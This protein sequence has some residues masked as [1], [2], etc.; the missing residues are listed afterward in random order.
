MNRPCSESPP[1]DTHCARTFVS[2][3][4]CLTLLLGI[5]LPLVYV[6]T[7]AVAWCRSPSLVWLH[8]GRGVDG[9]YDQE[10]HLGWP[11]TYFF[12]SRSA[13]AFARRPSS[14]WWQ[15]PFPAR[16]VVVYIAPLQLVV[17][18]AWAI[19]IVYSSRRVALR[20]LNADG[21][22]RFSLRTAFAVMTVSALLVYLEFRCRD[23]G[24]LWDG[25]RANE[26]Y[27]GWSALCHW[28]G[29]RSLYGWLCRFPVMVRVPIV[30]GWLSVVIV[31][32]SSVIAAQRSLWSCNFCHSPS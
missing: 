8:G 26:P 4:A 15:F 29:T 25:Y 18:V 12:A 2:R 20:A 23:T 30:L 6:N 19:A 16:G 14:W 11:T 28:L 24:Q 7:L 5:V 27:L 32:C 9:L 17:N 31:A 1:R 22:G 21:W 13:V 3:A 10:G